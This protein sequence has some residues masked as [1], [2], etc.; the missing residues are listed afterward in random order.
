MLS[1]SKANN[2][3]DLFA[4]Q[5]QTDPNDDI[6]TLLRTTKRF[7][8]STKALPSEHLDIQKLSEF[9]LPED[10]TVKQDYYEARSSSPPTRIKYVNFHRSEPLFL[11]SGRRNQIHLYSIKDAEPT[12]RKIVQL[13]DFAVHQVD[14]TSKNTCVFLTAF[15]VSLLLTSKNREFLLYYNVEKDAFSRIFN[16]GGTH[17]FLSS[18][19]GYKEMKNS[20]MYVSP[21]G[22][23]CLL[24]GE[25][26]TLFNVDLRVCRPS[27]AR[28]LASPI[29]HASFYDNDTCYML[30]GEE[31]V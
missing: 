9:T 25:K 14:W 19:A 30:T 3:D 27:D 7:I 15:R 5:D 1:I 28:Q 23:H 22:E 13:S 2:T 17:F 6:A 31:W 4:L 20:N 10:L 24:I 29:R 8:G 12:C 16:V 26:G 11:V 21:D 18:L